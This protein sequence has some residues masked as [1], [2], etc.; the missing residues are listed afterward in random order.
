MDDLTPCRVKKSTPDKPW[1]YLDNRFMSIRQARCLSGPPTHLGYC[2]A[3]LDSAKKLF[4]WYALA[5]TFLQEPYPLWI[6]AD[7][8]WA[9]DIPT[10]LER[11]VFQSAFAIAFAENDCVETRFPANNPV[12]GVRELIIHNPMNPLNE[13]SFWSATMRPYCDESAG[14]TTR[15]LIAA[16]DQLFTGWSRI[17]HRDSEVSI[18][19]R[20]YMLDDAPLTLGAGIVQ[21]RDFAREADEQALLRHLARVQETL[22]SAKREFFLL[23][24]SKDGLNY[25]GLAKRHGLRTLT[26]PS[27]IQ[28]RKTPKQM[29]AARRRTP[30]KTPAAS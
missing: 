7:N 8:L 5:R 20:P 16:V 24:T 30:R 26:F 2:A 1:L 23:V 3:N 6:D 4:F 22:K 17:L 14:E 18:S 12:R 25:F 27:T 28:P 11:R 19:R 15:T 10:G 13:E 29:I 21:I 9:P